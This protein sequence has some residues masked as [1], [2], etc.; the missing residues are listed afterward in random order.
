M[1][2]C[3]S[4]PNKTSLKIAKNGNRFAGCNSYPDCKESRWFHKFVKNIVVL[5][6]K[7]ER[8]EEDSMCSVSVDERMV[9]D[10][11]LLIRLTEKGE[12]GLVICINPM[13]SHVLYEDQRQGGG[14]Y[15][16]N[17]STQSSGGKHVSQP[18]VSVK[19][20]RCQQTGHYANDCPST[21]QQPKGTRPNP[22]PPRHNKP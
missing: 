4:C 19:C 5:E 1:F 21:S 17:L 9:D 11:G 20:Y 16:S 12:E 6:Q 18:K 8:C 10:V 22:S 2:Q 13:C 15:S 7:C 3:P 14:N